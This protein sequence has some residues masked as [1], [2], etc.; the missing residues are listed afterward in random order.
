MKKNLIIA[1]FCCIN[2]LS[3]AQLETLDLKNVV[4]VALLDKADER[5]TLEVN[6]SEILANQGIKTMASLNALKQGTDIKMIGSDSIVSALKSKG[7][8]T[9]VLVSV[10]GYDTKFKKATIFNDLKTE[11]GIGHA[12]PLYRDAIVSITLDFNFYRDGK[13]VAYDM[14]RFSGTSSRDQV[15]K[16]IRKKLPKRIISD[17]K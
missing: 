2:A 17:W 12:F 8:D 10:R 9:Y 14:Y 3:F 13:H 7:Y 5:F 16:K 4:V 15:I 6:L 1:L 11:L